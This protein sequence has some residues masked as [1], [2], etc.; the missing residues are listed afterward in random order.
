[1][2]SQLQVLQ[3]EDGFPQAL[4]IECPVLPLARRQQQCD[5]CWHFNGSLLDNKSQMELVTDGVRTVSLKCPALPPF[6]TTTEK[7]ASPSK[8]VDNFS[9]V[10]A[11]S[12]SCGNGSDFSSMRLTTEGGHDGLLLHSLVITKSVSCHSAVFKSEMFSAPTLT[13]GSAPF[14][15]VV[16]QCLKRLEKSSRLLASIRHWFI[17]RDERVR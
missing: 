7:K 9:L 11:N 8:D 3:T 6:I 17:C 16:A 14:P 10:P 15:W 13:Q 2:S 5:R 12:T 4:S 1:M